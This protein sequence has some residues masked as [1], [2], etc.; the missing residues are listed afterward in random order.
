[1]IYYQKMHKEELKYLFSFAKREHASG[2]KCTNF[3]LVLGLI[4]IEDRL[5]FRA[6]SIYGH[7]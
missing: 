3:R 2:M 5:V 6:V 7:A 1:M 4:I